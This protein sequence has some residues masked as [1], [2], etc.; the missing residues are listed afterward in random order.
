ME[1]NEILKELNKIF[2]D[3]LD[4]EKFDLTPETVAEDI[5]DWDSLVHIQ[6]I[7]AIEKYFKVKFT[8]DEIQEFKNV[9]DICL[10]IQKRSGV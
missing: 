8:F 4:N 6:F 7:V 10:L 3:I 1:T 9:G 2:R 5:D